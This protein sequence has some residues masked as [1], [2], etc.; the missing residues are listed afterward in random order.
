MNFRKSSTAVITFDYTRGLFSYS[1]DLNDRMNKWMTRHFLR[2]ISN[3]ATLRWLPLSLVALRD[4]LHNFYVIAW[5][6]S[7]RY[8]SRCHGISLLCL[9][10]IH[11]QYT[12]QPSLHL[13]SFEDCSLLLHV[14]Y[15]I[16]FNKTMSGRTGQS[17]FKNSSFATRLPFVSLMCSP[18]NTSDRWFADLSPSMDTTWLRY[19]DF[20]ICGNSMDP[21]THSRRS[22]SCQP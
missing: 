18:S 15:V 12:Q 3:L 16:S 6:V 4:R 1:S 9:P 8:G 10:N 14:V 11:C 19:T 17:T 20:A 2:Q 5:S 21:S 7:S 13:W 22:S